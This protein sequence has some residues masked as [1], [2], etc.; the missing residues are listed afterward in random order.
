MPVGLSSNMM[1][2]YCFLCNNYNFYSRL[3]EILLIGFSRGAYTLR[4]LARFLADVGLLRRKGLVFLRPI[5]QL[6]KRNAGR[7]LEDEG[8]ISQEGFA[9]IRMR[10]ALQ[11]EG[12]LVLAP[13]IKVLAEWDPV[14]AKGV[15]KDNLAFASNGVPGNV[16]NAFLAYALHERRRNFTPMLWTCQ[17]SRDTNVKQCAFNGCHSDIGGGNLDCGLS[18]FSLLWM[19]AQ[20][21]GVCDA[22]FDSKCLVQFVTP[23]PMRRWQLRRPDKICLYN[24]VYTKCLSLPTSIINGILL[25]IFEK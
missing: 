15:L 25:L 18:T 24:L 2:A 22:A 3:D 17:L 16:E 5:Y 13:K 4:C 9:L 11:R 23:L 14:S 19:V 8:S 10:D 7:S 1:D 21:Q 12:I 20:I 6:W